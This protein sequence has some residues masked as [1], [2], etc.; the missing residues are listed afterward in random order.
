MIKFFRKIRQRLLS[1]NRFSKYLLYAIGEIL[2]VVIGILIALN[3]N[4]NNELKKQRAQ[5]LHYLKNIKTDLK[6]NIAHL[7]NYI[8]T[9]QKAINSANAI[10]AHYEGQPIEDLKAFSRKTIDI[11]TWQK[12]SQI[13][14]TFQELMNSGNLALISNDSI[15]G[16]LLNMESLYKSLKS[17]E[18]HF[19]YD[20]E[21]M[22]YEPSYK[23]MDMNPIVQNYMY[24]VSEGAVGE[25]RDLPK[26]E[27]EAMLKDTQ[28][29]NGFVMAVYE[30]TVMNNQFRQ[31]KDMC[32]KLI[33]LIDKEIELDD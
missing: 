32:Q 29:K 5:E 12:F 24:Y 25:N 14:N 3:I 1:E 6:L 27:F 22:L 13:N 16:I 17:E 8:A 21:I 26:V 7:N 4:N 20:A 19:R 33:E 23:M 28:Q 15:K 31:M 30:F 11:Y 10:I 18:E 9:R 2:L